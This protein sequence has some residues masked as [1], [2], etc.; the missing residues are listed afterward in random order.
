MIAPR[1]GLRSPAIS[2]VAFPAYILCLKLAPPNPYDVIP[3]PPD[4]L[5]LFFII[6]ASTYRTYGSF[7]KSRSVNPVT[8]FGLP[9]YMLTREFLDPE[10]LFP[11]IPISQL[12]RIFIP[13]PPLWLIWF[14]ATMLQGLSKIAMPSCRLP[15][16]RLA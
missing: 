8:G 3:L 9:L 7:F 12:L 14:D 11:N 2:F 16:T 4:D 13:S 1:N 10:I 15:Q 6:S 5:K